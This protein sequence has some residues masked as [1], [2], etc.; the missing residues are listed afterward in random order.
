MFKVYEKTKKEIE[1]ERSNSEFLAEILNTEVDKVC[2]YYL[3]KKT[4][5]KVDISD[6]KE[7]E[8][9]SIF[10][11]ILT[12]YVDDK[13]NVVPKH[14]KSEIIN[15][16]LKFSKV[17]SGPDINYITSY[18]GL[19][20]VIEFLEHENPV[21]RSYSKDFFAPLLDDKLKDVETITKYIQ[22]SKGNY[23]TPTKE[24]KIQ[25]IEQIITNEENRELDKRH[26]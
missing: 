18:K 16:A 22:E 4:G 8:I 10:K 3:L 12:R 20:T 15:E 19:K 13:E 11:Q 1:Y 17:L 21:V 25:V 14:L 7:T 26:K 5:E 24:Q 2:P 23:E 9:L 6:L